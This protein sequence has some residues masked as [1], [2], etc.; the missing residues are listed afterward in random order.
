M[1]DGFF[2]FSDPKVLATM[3]KIAESFQNIYPIN[4][5]AQREA[6]GVAIGRYPEDLYA[7][8]HFRA[9]NPWVLCTLA[10]AEAY[11]RGAAELAA[12]GQD[13]RAQALIHKGDAYVKRV[14]YHSHGNGSLNEQ[15]DRHSGF[16]TSVEDLTWN[17]AAV[18]T[19]ALARQKALLK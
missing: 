3:D 9:G 15:I 6:M 14:Q 11:Y 8:S 10:F 4:R 18:W 1:N 12:A 5:E 16:M 19:T 17:Y 7:G 2:K 13:S